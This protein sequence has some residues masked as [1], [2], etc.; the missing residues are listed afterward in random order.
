MKETN[1]SQ[2]PAATIPQ[3]G[4]RIKEFFES[5]YGSLIRYCRS[6][7]NSQGEDVAHTAFELAVNRYEF[8]TFGLFTSLCKEAARNI[9]I[10]WWQH[11]EEQTIVMPPTAR[12]A[13]RLELARFTPRECNILDYYNSAERKLVKHLLKA[14]K[15]GKLNLFG[16]AR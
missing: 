9:G 12:S 7:W 14:E 3:Q 13:E 4:Q 8:I 16:G 5:N 6:K 1:Y 11:D 10:Q 15:L 2:P